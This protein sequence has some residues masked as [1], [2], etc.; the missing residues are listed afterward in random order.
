VSGVS[1]VKET[2]SGSY[3]TY[4]SKNREEFLRSE[5]RNKD[6]IGALKLSKDQ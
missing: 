6:E 4:D 1:L 3:S 2:I 5:G